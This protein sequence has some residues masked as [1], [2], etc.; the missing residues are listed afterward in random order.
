MTILEVTFDQIT[1]ML[2]TL[3]NYQEYNNPAKKATITWN[4]F[5]SSV[6]QVN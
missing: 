5:D 2:L 6:W 4:L 3:T 1:G